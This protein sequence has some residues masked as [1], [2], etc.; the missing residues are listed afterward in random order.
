M[1]LSKINIF[2]FLIILAYMAACTKPKQANIILEKQIAAIK[3]D[4][5]ILPPMI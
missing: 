1:E 2:C 3:K 5:I 4:C